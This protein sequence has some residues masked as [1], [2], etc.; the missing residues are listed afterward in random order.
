MK[1]NPEIT[2]RQFI[3]TRKRW[4]WE[5]RGLWNIKLDGA[6]KNL[7]I[8]AMKGAEKG[9]GNT[10]YHLAELYETGTGVPKDFTK[11]IEWYRVSAKLGYPD[12]D[13]WL[14]EKGF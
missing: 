2:K 11:A 12:A 10:A 9:I 14:K 4:S 5:C 3:G 7:E 6:M 8:S 1:E 13:L